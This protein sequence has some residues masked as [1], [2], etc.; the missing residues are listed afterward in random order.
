MKVT[1]T[2]NI[3]VRK[4]GEDLFIFDRKMSIIHSL[5]KIGTFIWEKLAAEVAPDMI[6]EKI[7]DAF[8]VDQKT[9]HTD[10]IEYIR[11]LESKKLITVD[12]E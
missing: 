6:V 11:E 7:C 8:E 9:A 4:I 3:S 1:V 10:V 2:D 5:N 12:Y